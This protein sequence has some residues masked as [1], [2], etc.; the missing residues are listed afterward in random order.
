MSMGRKR[1]SDPS[2]VGAMIYHAFRNPLRAG[3]IGIA[4]V[5]VIVALVIMSRDEPTDGPGPTHD[6]SAPDISQLPLIMKSLPAGSTVNA[7]EKILGFEDVEALK[8]RPD[9]IVKPPE[10][11]VSPDNRADN[12][13]GA[14]LNI[15][16]ATKDGVVYMIT[17][18]ELTTTSK[19]HT[20]P[21]VDC[22]YSTVERP[23]GFTVTT[24][25]EGP[26]IDG[27]KVEAL[28]TVTRADNRIED[29]YLF[30]TWIDPRRVVSV[31]VRSDPSHLPP[32][33]PIDPTLAKEL[34]GRA[35]GIIRTGH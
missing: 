33:N 17:A 29:S 32:A 4:V 13:L 2:K 35:V 23:N 28:H 30:R 31:V 15:V 6:A 11:G 7:G 18:Q 14:R 3:L 12:V 22:S 8:R 24:P 34:L 25:T 20:D 9:G 5:G 1:N 19:P 27:L 21:V 26:R 16:N 10:C